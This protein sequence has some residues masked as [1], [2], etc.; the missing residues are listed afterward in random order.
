MDGSGPAMGIE[1]S[2]VVRLL[3]LISFFLFA[4]VEAGNKSVEVLD[5]SRLMPSLIPEPVWKTY[6]FSITNQVK[7]L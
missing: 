3:L 2:A 4:Q 1:V 6:R 5:L 7:D